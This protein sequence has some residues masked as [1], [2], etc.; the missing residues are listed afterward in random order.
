MERLYRP[1]A[2]P[3]VQESLHP[4]EALVEYVLGANDHSYALE[5]TRGTVG[6]RTLPPRTEIDKLVRAYLASIK[7]KG[8]WE[9]L[10]RKLFDILLAPALDNGVDSIIIVPDGSLHLVPFASLLDSASQY[11][12]RSMPLAFTPSATVLYI[13]RTQQTSATPTKPFLGIAYS[14]QPPSRNTAQAAESLKPVFDGQ[15]RGLPALPYAVQEVGTAAELFGKKSVLLSGK[16]AS[17]AALKAEPLQDFKIIH[18]AAHGVGSTMEPDHAALI[19]APGNQT[20]DGLWQAREIRATH[21][22]ADLVTLSACETGVGRLEG[23]EGVMNLARTFLAAGAK[24][25]VASLWDTDDRFSATLMDRFY[26][27]IAEGQTV[28][29]ALRT[30]QLDMLAVFGKDV[31]PYYWAGFTVIGDGTKRVFQ[32]TRGPHLQ[33]ARSDIRQDHS[34]GH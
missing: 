29:E 14:P 25:V 23:E 11:A 24:S 7:Q 15:L 20:E 31:Q 4:G 30:A 27:H 34:E 1:V 32:Q 18:I 17:E 28:A 21:L 9:P 12:I 3:Q 8:D 13:L 33:A 22:S 10:A 19:L 26:R 2:L 5:I 16:Q 6:I